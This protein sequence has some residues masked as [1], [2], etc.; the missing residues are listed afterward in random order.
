G[1]KA[2]FLPAREILS[3]L[4]AIV[5]TRET[6]EI[7]A[8]DD[9][10][11]DLVRD[12][13]LPTVS[14]HWNACVLQILEH[15]Q[16]VTGG[17]EVELQADGG[18]LLRRGKE[19][20]NMHQ[21]AEGIRKIAILSRLMR[22][23][24]LTPGAGCMLF[25]DEPE[26]SLQPRAVGLFV[27]MLHAFAR[28]GVRV[29]LSTRSLFLLKLLQQVAHKHRTDDTLLE[30]RKTPA[31]GVTGTVSPLR[32]GLPLIPIFDTP[33]TLHDADVALDRGGDAPA[34]TASGAA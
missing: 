15:L 31:G 22:N 30:L 17:G 20:L 6:M 29:Y 5:A 3:I 9:T 16:E 12:V 14:G 18:I 21:T 10:C 13:R 33:P 25:F 8:F 19:R 34:S 2:T 26:A 4:D 23:G 11:Y 32:D 1:F 24:R 7:A 27:D 28:S